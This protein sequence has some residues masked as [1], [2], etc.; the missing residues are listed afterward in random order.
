MTSR[1]PPFAPKEESG[2]PPAPFIVGAPR[3]GTT[4]LRLMLDAHPALAIPPETGFLPAV[5]ALRSRAAPAAF[6]SLVTGFETWSDFGLEARDLA[7]ALRDL[8]PFSLAEAVRAFYLRYARRF[9]KRLWGDKTPDYGLHLPAIRSLLPEA[10]FIHLI[11]DGRDVALSLR[12]LWFAPSRRVQDL[13]RHWVQR[14][15]TTRALGR[16]SSHYLEVRFED[17]VRRPADQLAVLCRFLGI[18]YD[19][20]MLRYHERAST[21]LDEHQER[22]HGNGSLRLAKAER[23]SQQWRTQ[24]PPDLSR[25]GCHRSEMTPEERRAFEGVAGGLLR[26]LGYEV[27]D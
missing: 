6:L 19:P 18:D 5:L 24:L 22:R 15:S 8:T 23:R 20:A 27:G 3:S 17:L 9:G 2:L 14:V 11:R 25:I 13:A 1:P 21:R 7:A 26:E 10:R 4:L 12:P 16:G